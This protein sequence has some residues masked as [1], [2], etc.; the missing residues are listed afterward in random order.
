[1]IDLK[2]TEI[3][4]ILGVGIFVVISIA[5]FYFLFPRLFNIKRHNKDAFTH[6]LKTAL[7]GNYKDTAFAIVS[8]LLVY[9]AGILTQNITDHMTDSERNFN[10]LISF[11]NEIVFL[12][13]NS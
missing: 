12:F 3:F 10:P 8:A 5:Y 9:S 2:L 6:W 7:N 1:M 13:S 11:V 4:S